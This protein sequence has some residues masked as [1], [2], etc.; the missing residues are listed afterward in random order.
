[1]PYRAVIFELFHTLVEPDDFSPVPARGKIERA[2][3]ALGVDPGDFRRFW[4]WSEGQ[5][6]RSAA[7]TVGA[8]LKQYV[9][10]V[11][12][13]ASERALANAE[14]ELGIGEDG[15]LRH[16]DP[17]A[18]PTLAQL[19]AAG[20]RLG[21]LSNADER[22]ARGWVCCPLAPYFR[23]VAF[24]HQ[25]GLVKPEPAAFRHALELVGAPPGQTAFVGDGAGG[26][27]GAARA[28]GFGLVVF[29]RGHV[30]RTGRCRLEDLAARA[31]AAHVVV[32]RLSAL[33]VHLLPP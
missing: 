26:E 8:A 2:A 24:S 16:P 27:L 11:G 1:V 15:A 22:T 10:L 28:L 12:R 20:L 31:A 25:T 18:G 21:L 3:R 33:P 19:A 9:A 23:A 4:L 32:D 17:E 30:T 13:T 29:L 5:R 6:L 7:S 14:Q